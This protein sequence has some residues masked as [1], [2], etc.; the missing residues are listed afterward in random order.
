MIIYEP[1]WQTLK[2]SGEST[3]SLINRHGISSSTIN[4]L[5]KNQPINTTTIDDICSALGCPVEDVLRY[6]PEE[7]SV[8]ASETVFRNGKSKFEHDTIVGEFFS[9]AENS[10][11]EYM[12]RPRYAGPGGTSAAPKDPAA[13]DSTAPAPSD[14]ASTADPAKKNIE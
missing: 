7:A 4:R 2:R 8:S 3:Y 14:P 1:F 13:S 10:E 9:V 11:T 12:F 5:R 6:L